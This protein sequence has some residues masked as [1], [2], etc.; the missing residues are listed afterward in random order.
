MAVTRADI[1]RIA[2]L[3][4][5]AVDDAAA[6]ELERQLSRILD[7]VAQ[8]QALPDVGGAAPPEAAL[9]LRRDEVKPDALA[10][11]PETFAPSLKHGLFLVPRVAELAPGTA[12]E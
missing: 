11:G 12:D 6:A 4:E 10:A 9:R 8:L 3:A 7:H 5:L 1:Q 2:D